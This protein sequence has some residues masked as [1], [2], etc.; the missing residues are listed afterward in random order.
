MKELSST[1]P[2]KSEIRHC[3]S[4][5][6]FG[7]KLELGSPEVYYIH[8]CLFVLMNPTRYDGILLL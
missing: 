1:N 2:N 4:K 7:G 3:Y 6:S 8:F 5:L